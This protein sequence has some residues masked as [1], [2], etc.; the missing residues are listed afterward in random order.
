MQRDFENFRK[1]YNVE[2]AY[3]QY[4]YKCMQKAW[5]QIFAENYSEN[6]YNIEYLK[7]AHFH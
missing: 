3:L 6:F 7:Q 1:I 4:Y 5:L 2:H